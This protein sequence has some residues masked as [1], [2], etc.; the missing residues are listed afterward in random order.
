MDINLKLTN[1]ED[2]QYLQ[3]IEDN[4]RNEF[5]KVAITIGLKSI[6]MSSVNMDCNS[7]IEPIREIIS[8][9]TEEN[10]MTIRNI[11]DKLD[12][13]LHIRTNSSRKGRLSEDICIN[14]LIQN[15]P[16]WDFNNVTQVGHEG[17]CRAMS[18]IGEIL[19]E[20]K[21]YDT[22]VNKEQIKKFYKDLEI[23]GIK[24]G[25]FVSNTSGIVGKKNLEW[26]IIKNNT[27][28]VYISNMGFNGHGCI[29]GTEL[30]LALISNNILKENNWLIHQNYQN[31]EIYKNLVESIDDYRS[32]AQ[33]IN[34]LH[35]HIKDHRIKMNN[36][37]DTLE[38]E[39]FQIV[40]NTE[41]TFSKILGL[42][43]SIKSKTDIIAELNI[44]DY[45]L[46][47]KHSPKFNSIYIQ[48]HK[49]CLLHKLTVSVNGDEWFIHKD[50]KIIAKTKTLKSKIQ[51]IIDIIPSKLILDVEHEEYKDKNIIITLSDSHKL[52]E[53][54]SMRF[55]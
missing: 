55:S 3:G 39:T 32:D 18:P 40:L 20:F 33:L 47:S 22:N 41:I 43:E 26:E 5:I 34:K 31:D 45:I 21:S 54:V 9:S 42:V 49:L 52:W 13:L 24:L 23:T 25:I 28:V 12:S 10:I 15:Y 4:K 35:K 37:I 7:Y 8:E 53:T 38:S 51:L 6:Q 14:R 46:K 36:M 1:E 19:Y 50:S 44:D 11:D 48:L 30:L 16:T 17:D 27:L 2:V 29:V